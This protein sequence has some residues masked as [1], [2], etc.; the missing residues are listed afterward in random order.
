MGIPYF[1]LPLY[2]P[3]M[4]PR[5]LKTIYLSSS[6]RGLVF[7]YLG[8]LYTNVDEGLS[9]ILLLNMTTAIFDC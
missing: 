9:Q 5:I 6:A 4:C 3:Q 2:P 8:Y 7:I 1:Q